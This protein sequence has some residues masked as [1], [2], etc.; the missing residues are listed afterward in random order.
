VIKDFL[1]DTIEARVCDS[2]RDRIVSGALPPLARL[3]LTELA[4]AYGVSTMPVR[5]ALS[6]LEAEGLVV[7]RP[8]RR[9]LVAPMRLEDFEEIQAMRAGIEGFA[10]RLGAVAIDREEL[11][12]LQPLLADLLVAQ[13][14]ADVDAYL[15]LAWAVHRACY[16]AAGRERLLGQIEDVRR[17]AERYI[18]LAVA[19]NPGLG[20]AAR[21]QERLVDACERHDGPLAERTVRDALQWTIRLVAPALGSGRAVSGGGAALRLAS[22]KRT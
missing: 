10:A 19:S 1:L 15:K 9:S 16:R 18:R 14:A 12:Q 22:A 8:R 20:N 7:Q 17:R 21:Y 6:K 5:T 13:E 11:A 3:R 2:L 4:T